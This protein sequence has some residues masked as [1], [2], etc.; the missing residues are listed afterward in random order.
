MVKIGGIGPR[1]GP[2]IVKKNSFRFFQNC[3]LVQK[4]LSFKKGGW[5]ACSEFYVSLNITPSNQCVPI[6]GQIVPAGCK[7]KFWLL[8]INYRDG[9]DAGVAKTQTCIG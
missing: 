1:S 8:N 9:R 6:F 4:R 3:F 5:A 7:S 2:E